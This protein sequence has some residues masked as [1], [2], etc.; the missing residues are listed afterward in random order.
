M[1]QLQAVLRRY[2]RGVASAAVPG[3]GLGLSVVAAIVHLHHFALELLPA[4]P[5]LRARIV[6]PV[7][8][9]QAR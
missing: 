9:Q 5:G 6:A 2:D 7:E 4:E 1:D 8:A 3:S